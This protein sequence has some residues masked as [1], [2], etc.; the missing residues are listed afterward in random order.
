MRA[1]N[2][3][4]DGPVQPETERRLAAETLDRI[5]RRALPE[6]DSV[7]PVDGSRYTCADARAAEIAALFKRQ[8]LLA[9][10]GCEIA[11]PGDYLTLVDLAK[12]SSSHVAS[13]RPEIVPARRGR[14][15][16][17]T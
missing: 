15:P 14:P 12:T 2:S 8:P 17:G 11:A 6:A 4:S 10:F 3:R 9:A 5:G 13:L 7:M 1:E 16:C